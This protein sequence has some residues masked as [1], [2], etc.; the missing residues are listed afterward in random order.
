MNRFRR[1]S[2]GRAWLTTSYQFLGGIARKVYASRALMSEELRSVSFVFVSSRGLVLA[3]LILGA[4]FVPK[5]DPYNPGTRIVS[6]SVHKIQIAR[7]LKRE[8]LVGD[9][10][11]YIGIA[12]HGYEHSAFE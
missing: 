7:I 10:N 11:W 9:A 1:H 2:D 5:E 8:V 6:L 12:A 3:I 4:I